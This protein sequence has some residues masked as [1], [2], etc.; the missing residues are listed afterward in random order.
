M[1]KHILSFL[2]IHIVYLLKKIGN[3]ITDLDKS[4]FPCCYNIVNKQEDIIGNLPTLVVGYQ[5]AMSMFGK[6]DTTDRCDAITGFFWTFGKLESRQDFEEDMERF[7]ATCVKVACSDVSYMYL[8]ISRYR[9]SKLKRVIGFIYGKDRKLCYFTRDDNF[10]F[11]YCERLSSV[12]GLSL[13]LLEYM[14]IDKEKVVE[15]I[16]SNKNNRFVYN[17]KDV[18]NVLGS[19][20]G[21]DTHLIPVLSE[22]VLMQKSR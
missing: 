10:V 20:I 6:I 13:S 3:I 8:D 22:C 15:K 18:M 14:G 21:N 5:K 9:Y 7:A 17:Y 16:R 1:C 2:K 4:K 19:A 12:F 11:I